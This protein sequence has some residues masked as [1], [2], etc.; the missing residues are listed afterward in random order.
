M[1]YYFFQA[2]P[3][4]HSP[5]LSIHI[6]HLLLQVLDFRVF[7]T[8]PSTLYPNQPYLTWVAHQVSLPRL[9]SPDCATND[10]SA[11]VRMLPTYNSTHR[12]LPCYIQPF[13]TSRFGPTIHF[14]P[15]STCCTPGKAPSI[16]FTSLH[17]KHFLHPWAVKF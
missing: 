15:G 14:G 13:P 1:T 10:L 3:A 16:Y 11:S 2:P 12:L 4:L 7:L 8:S 9:T 17:S 5:S 6:S